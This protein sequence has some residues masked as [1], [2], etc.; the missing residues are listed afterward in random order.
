MNT[1]LLAI[2]WWNFAG[3][4]MMLGFLYQPF[5]QKMLNEWTMIFK[6]KFVLDYWGKLWFVWAAGLNIFFGLV[7]IM[8]VKWGYEEVKLFLIWFDIIGYLMVVGFVV[9]GLKA[10]RLLRSGSIVAVVIFSIW[11]IWGYLVVR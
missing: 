6:E 10:G 1:Y 11:I 8:A 3:S 4:I 5:G 2:G 9:W 7:N